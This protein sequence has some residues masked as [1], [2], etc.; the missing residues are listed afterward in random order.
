MRIVCKES[1]A[2]LQF[3]KEKVSDCIYTYNYIIPDPQNYTISILLDGVEIENSP[4]EVSGIDQSSIKLYGAGLSGCVV[5]VQGEFYIDTKHAG[6]GSIGLALE[7][8]AQTPVECTEVED[9]V[10][11]V[12]YVPTCPGLYSLNVSFSEK[13][14]EGSPFQIPVSRRAPDAGRVK[15][16]DL[17]THGRFLVDARE[18]GG[19]G[20]LQVGVTGKFYPAEFISVKHNGDFTFTVTYDLLE[21][22]PTTISV[23]WHGVEIENSPFTVQT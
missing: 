21:T 8:P 9:G 1:N 5:S 17:K 6:D 14:V 16:M 4:Y 19:S 11:K 13:V 10:Y 2:K 12:C 22:G 23:K 20:L 7:G 15:V 18:A 3:T